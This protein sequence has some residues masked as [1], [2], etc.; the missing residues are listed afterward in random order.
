MIVANSTWTLLD[1]ALE[2]WADCSMKIWTFLTT[3]PSEFKGGVVWEV[4]INVN[5]G[6]KYIA[7]ALLVVFFGMGV[8]KEITNI[9]ELKSPATV[10]KLFI[11]YIVAK[12]MIT[13]SL[14]LMD[15]VFKIC[16]GVIK[17]I[18]D[19]SEWVHI[20]GGR[21]GSLPKEVS[22]AL[23]EANFLE[24][25][26]LGIFEI[27]GYLIIVALSIVAVMSVYGRFFKLYIYT[28]LAPV[29]L[30]AI[31]GEPTQNHGWQFI[32]SYIGVCFEGAVIAI[33]CVIYSKIAATNT[34]SAMFSNSSPVGIVGGYLVEVIFNMLIMIGVIKAA[35]QIVHEMTNL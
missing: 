18:Y 21:G 11:R 1:D 24:N 34:I 25:I 28:A 31:A 4:M 22:A 20:Y 23:S 14:D 13:Y 10:F 3:A 33:A 8:L 5:D 26:P 2:F 27:L 32:K 19:S 35:S 30:A 7:Y 29:P 9:G 17:K 16:G 12:A 15:A 6:I